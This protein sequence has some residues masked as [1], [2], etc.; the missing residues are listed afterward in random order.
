MKSQGFLKQKKNKIVEANDKP[1]ILRGVNF[2][3]W[4]MME[5]YILQSPN[6]AVKLFKKRFKDALG[7]KALREFEET[8][9]KE[10][11]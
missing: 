2:G 5:G 10:H 6:E 8:F 11:D 3:S 7:E 1:I 9:N 4:L